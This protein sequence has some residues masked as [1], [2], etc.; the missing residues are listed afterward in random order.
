MEKPGWATFIG[1][2][3]LLIG[4]C[5]VVDNLGDMGADKLLELQDEIS[6][7]IQTIDNVTIQIDTSESGTIDSSDVQF[8]K[9]FGDSIVKDSNDNVDVKETFKN[10]IKI[11]PYRIKWIKTFARV[12]MIVSAMFL[13]SGIFFLSR[14][15][16]VIQLALLTLAISLGFEFFQIIIFR[17]DADT[18]KMISTFSNAEIYLGMFIDVALLICIMVLDKS[19]YNEDELNEDYYDTAQ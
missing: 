3:M 16:Y 13:I 7:E 12:G 9:M 15:K 17:A 6:D 14:K 18:G 11:S 1:I 4:G 2:I 8:I 10:I 5:S 19:F